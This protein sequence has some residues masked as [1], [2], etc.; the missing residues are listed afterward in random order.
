MSRRDHIRRELA[1]ALLNFATF[2]LLL[3]GMVAPLT[4]SEGMPSARDLIIFACGPLILLSLA[5]HG[6]PSRALKIFIATEFF[7]L[8]AFLAMHIL[9]L[10]RTSP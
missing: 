6:A 5:H 7:L 8:A 10:V 9:S 3:V 1:A 4:P 2:P